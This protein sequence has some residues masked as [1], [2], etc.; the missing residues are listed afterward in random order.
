MNRLV[1]HVAQCAGHQINTDVNF[2]RLRDLFVLFQEN[3]ISSLESLDGKCNTFSWP[4]VGLEV[5]SNP[6]RTLRL[7]NVKI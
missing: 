3:L 7:I 1:C 2:C 6:Q 4:F 5:I